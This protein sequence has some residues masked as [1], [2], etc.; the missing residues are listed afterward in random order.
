M[1]R[2][3]GSVSA[4]SYCRR[5]TNPT[6]HLRCAA[7]PRVGR[8]VPAATQ[9]ILSSAAFPVR[10]ILFD[11]TPSANLKVA[12]HQ[13]RSIAVKRRIDVPGYGPWSVKEG[14]EHV[15]ELG[16]ARETRKIGEG[17]LAAG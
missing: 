4:C 14:I 12:W 5:I 10:A 3:H 6:S 8:K 16:A 1:T 17:A 9:P 13:D 11:K 7:H 2:S 15:R